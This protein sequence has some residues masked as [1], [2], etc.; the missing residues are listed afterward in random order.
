[1]G[2]SWLIIHSTLI[3][4]G[5]LP[6]AKWE[7]VPEQPVHHH[8]GKWIQESL[9]M[10]LRSLRNTEGQKDRCKD[11]G[12]VQSV[13]QSPGAGGVG[14]GLDTERAENRVENARNSTRRA[15]AEVPSLSSVQPGL[16]LCFYNSPGASKCLHVMSPP[17]PGQSSGICHTGL[18]LVTNHQAAQLANDQ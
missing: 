15:L 12:G 6:H 9:G 11:E 8:S 10:G 18:I 3:P 13:G 5:P 4:S 7:C 2:P 1:M 17:C 14:R 16:L